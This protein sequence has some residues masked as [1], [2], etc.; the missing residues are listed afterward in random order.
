MPG[1]RHSHFKGPK[2]G[3]CIRSGG[4]DEDREEGR[5]GGGDG[6]RKNLGSALWCLADIVRFFNFS[7]ERNTK[8]LE[9]FMEE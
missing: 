9:D 8:P 5:E 7:F 1:R 4:K 3:L 6:T 2:E